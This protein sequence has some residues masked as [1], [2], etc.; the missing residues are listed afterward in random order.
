MSGEKVRRAKD[1]EHFL[2]TSLGGDEYFL[3]TLQ[4]GPANL[5]LDRTRD[6]QAV[7][8]KLPRSLLLLRL[9]YL[10]SEPGLGQPPVQH[11]RDWRDA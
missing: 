10:A 4:K 6:S 11:D 2:Q 1:L 7:L 9:L 8:T 5:A 3:V